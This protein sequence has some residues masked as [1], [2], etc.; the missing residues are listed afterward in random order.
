[1]YQMICPALESFQAT[2]GLDASDGAGTGADLAGA[3]A[4]AA[5][6]RAA[7]HDGA[8]GRLAPRVYD[9]AVREALVVLWEASDRICGKRFEPLLPTLVDAMERHGH[10]DLAEDAGGGPPAIC[11]HGQGAPPKRLPLEPLGADG[12]GNG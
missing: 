11:P 3:W 2:E 7:R 9:D 1:M 8:P 6:A 5:A 12:N 10:L 4:Q